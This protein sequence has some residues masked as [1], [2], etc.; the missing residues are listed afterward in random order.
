M[1]S[2]LDGHPAFFVLPVEFQYFKFPSIF[3][4]P[5]GNMPA[6]P[7]PDW[8]TPVPREEV[9]LG[10][11]REEI[12]R[13]GELGSLLRTGD[14]GRNI[15]LSESEFDSERFLAALRQAS[16]SDLRELYLALVAAVATAV[17]GAEGQPDQR[18]FVEKCPHME[19]YA[20]LLKSWFPEAKFVHMLRNP[21]ANLFSLQA[22]LVRKRHF[23][24]KALRPMAKSF[25]FLERNQA[26]L[27]DYHVV[28][29]EDLVLD[30]DATLKRLADHLE[31]GYRPSLQSPTILGR[32]W[33]G[34]PQ[35]VETSFEGIDPRP[36]DAFRDEISP[37][38]VALVNRFF[39]PFMARHG[40]SR[41]EV[42]SVKPWLPMRWEAP[43]HYCRS[44]W[45]WLRGTL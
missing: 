12:I 15:R 38:Q 40:Y 3:S 18:R 5:P 35:T 10:R 37:L 31:I 20:V 9:A 17:G 36:V 11:M 33:A 32:P 30:T 19:E 39:S 22:G 28:R 7:V 23:R 25:Y 26:C 16:V 6:P 29:Y 4:L 43:W 8:Q 13:S 41:I 1:Q 45:L 44:R 42:G 34:N 21:Y 14:V 24:E 2:L 27:D